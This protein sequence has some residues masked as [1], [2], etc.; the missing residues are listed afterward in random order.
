M[1]KFII[2]KFRRM[3]RQVCP[4]LKALYIITLRSAQN[5]RN[6][7]FYI[8]TTDNS[9]FVPIKMGVGRG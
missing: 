7:E 6:R 4:F 1:S 8:L 9:V 3:M 5:N 2:S